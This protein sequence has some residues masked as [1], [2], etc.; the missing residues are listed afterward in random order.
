MNRPVGVILIAIL[1]FIAAAASLGFGLVMIL[2]GGFLG[3]MLARSGSIPPA[4]GAFIAGLGVAL[5][6]F[7][8]FIAALMAA[9]GWGLLALKN[10]ARI[11]AIILAVIGIV[12]GAGSIMFALT[13]FN[14]FFMGGGLVR[15]AIA[16]LII[17]YLNQPHVKTA[18]GATQT[19][20]VS[21]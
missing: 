2:G 8:F 4:V 5:A 21:A 19:S 15:A 10:W 12:L 9:T 16:V 13:H 18:F 6:A 14:P 20:A 11:L 1:H 7:A 17:W 3:A